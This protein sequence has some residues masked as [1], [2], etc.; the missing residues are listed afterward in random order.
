MKKKKKIESIMAFRVPHDLLSETHKTQIRKDLCAKESKPFNRYKGFSYNKGKEI[1]FFSVDHTTKEIYLPM[2]YAGRLFNKPLINQRRQFHRVPGFKLLAKLR[3]YQ[4][5]IVDAS[6]QNYMREGTNFLN[7]FCSYGKTVATAYFAALFSQ[8]YGLVT[9][10]TYPG[11]IIQPSW[12]DT[13]RNLTTAKIYIVGEDLGPVDLDVQVILCMDTRLCKLEPEV[14]ARI[15]HF[16]IDEADLYCTKDHV[17][18]LMSVE[19]LLITALTATYE[20]DDGMHVM[21]DLL[22]GKERITKISR[23]PFFVFQIPTPFSPE[24]RQGKHGIIWDSVRKELDTIEAR[25]SL[26]LQTVL[27]NLSE[28]IMILTFHVSHA[29]SLATWLEYYLTPM[30]KTVSLIAKNIKT[31]QDANVIVATF[32]KAGRGFDEKGACIDWRGMRINMIIMATSVKKPEQYVGRAF[33]ADIPI[34]VDIVDNQN[35]CKTHWRLRRN[36][37]ESRNGIIY[38]TNDRFVWAN[39]KQPL[40]DVYFNSIQSQDQTIELVTADMQQLKIEAPRNYEEELRRAHLSRLTGSVKQTTPNPIQNNTM[41]QIIPVPTRQF[42][43]KRDYEGE[44]KNAHIAA[45]MKSFK[46]P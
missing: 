16:A 45:L 37:Y 13:F 42:S 2:H 21:L 14:R 15:G 26:I 39:I 23:K 31:Y 36:W 17:E 22:V 27:D 35:N 40:I 8:Q 4:E 7:V 25:N 43:S 29:E 38:S 6:L 18:G 5:E 20:R 46:N 3:D 10:I 34:I 19:P 41:R 30:G 24:G 28:K 33:R 44:L 32:S 12:I 11:T 9:L 1:H